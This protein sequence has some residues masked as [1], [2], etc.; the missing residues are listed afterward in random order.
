MPFASMI[1]AASE[2]EP[3]TEDIGTTLRRLVA[4]KLGIEPDELTPADIQHYRAEHIYP[5]MK[6]D[7]R[8]EY[9]GFLHQGE[10][11]LTDREIEELR[12]ETDEFFASLEHRSD[13][14][15]LA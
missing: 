8:S 12:T 6:L 5:T 2:E 7:T 15:S 3:A 14:R 9:G 1:R 11:C 4:P 13:T 10:R